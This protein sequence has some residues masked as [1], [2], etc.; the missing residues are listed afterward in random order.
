[1]LSILIRVKPTIKEVLNL[2][3]QN[4]MIKFVNSFQETVNE[5]QEFIARPIVE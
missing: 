2:Q 3:Q 5:M 4:Y 1:M